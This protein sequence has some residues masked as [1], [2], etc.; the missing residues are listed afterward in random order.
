LGD[1]AAKVK[2]SAEVTEDL[3]K[4]AEVKDVIVTVGFLFPLPLG[5]GRDPPSEHTG[6][7]NEE[8]GDGV[9]RED[10]ES[11]SEFLLDREGGGRG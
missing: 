10:L 9:E 8:Y 6:R 2:G 3:T 7:A 1:A 11:G 4:S 5:A